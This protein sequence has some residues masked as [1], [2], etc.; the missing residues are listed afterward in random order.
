MKCQRMQ[1]GYG[2]FIFAS[3]LCSSD[4]ELATV[5]LSTGRWLTP[6]FP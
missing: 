6:D 3:M 1:A 2:V 4:S 5:R